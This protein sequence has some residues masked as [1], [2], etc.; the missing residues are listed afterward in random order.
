LH[1]CIW[2]SIIWH[3][4]VLHHTTRK[5]QFI[6]PPFIGP[7]FKPYIKSNNVVQRVDVVKSFTSAWIR[8]YK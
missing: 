3:G 2:Y 7:R 1:T 5:S 8:V 6:G 4:K